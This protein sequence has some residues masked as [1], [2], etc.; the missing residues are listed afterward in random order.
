M[1]SLLL[2]F[3]EADVTST[4]TTFTVTSRSWFGGKSKGE[5]LKLGFQLGFSGSTTPKFT[6]IIINGKNVCGSGGEG[7]G[8]GQGLIIR[9]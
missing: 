7:G 1:L 6:S 2:K 3:W 9:P 4:G 5:A 8:P